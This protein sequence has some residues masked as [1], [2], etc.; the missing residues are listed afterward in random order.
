MRLVDEH[1]VIFGEVVKERP[2][3]AALCPL[4]QVASV[5]LDAGAET[6]LLEH[7]HVVVGAAFQAGRLKYFAVVPEVLEALFQLDS[8]ALDR[9]LQFLLGRNEVVRRVN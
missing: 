4:R 2:W 8:D 9:Q 5:V 1:Q 3:C 7:F 6:G